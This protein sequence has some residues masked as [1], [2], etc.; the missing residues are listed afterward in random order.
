MCIHQLNLL[1]ASSNS[2]PLGAL[3]GKQHP[4]EARHFSSICDIMEKAMVNGD[5]CIIRCILVVFQVVFRF[6]NPQSE[7]NKESV[8]RSGLL[9]WQL[10]MAPVDQIG[11]EIQREV[12]LAISSGLNTLYQGEAELSKLLKL[13]LTEGER[14]SGLSQLR[15]VILTNLADQLQKNRFGSEEDDHYRLS[16]E[17]LHCILKTVVRESCLI[18]TK[19]QTVARDDFQKLLSTVPVVSP[20]LRYLM[21]VQNHL[22]SNTILIRPDDNDDSDSSL[23]GETMKVQELQSSILSLATKILVGCDEVLETLQ[24]VTTALINS[25]IPDRET[26]L[27]GLEQVTKATMLGHL[28]PVLLTSLMHPNL[29]TLILADALMPQLVQLVLYTSQTALL[30]KTQAPLF[31]EEPPPQECVCVLD[32]RILDE[33]EEPGFLTGLKIPAP[34]AAGKT[35]ETVHPVR[36]NYKFK[37]TVHI[38]GARCLYLRFDSRCSSQYDYDKVMTLT[39]VIYAGPNTNSRKVTEY[40]GNTLGYGSRSVLGTGWPKD[41]VKVEGDT[42]TFSFEMRSGREHNTPDKAMWGFSCTVR[43]QESSEDVSGG[44]PFL[45][46]LALGLSVLACSMLRILYNGPE[47]TREEE[48]C[49]DLLCSKLLQRCQWQVEANGAISPALTPSPSPLPLTIEEDREFIYPSDVLIPPPGLMPGTYFDLPR[50]RL[51]P[52]VMGRLR[53]VSGRAR[54]QFRPSIK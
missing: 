22:L 26:R 20:S 34:W 47:V 27:K 15:D 48:A 13:V 38:P 49:H 36:D 8:R 33:R 1:A 5:T 50:I 29:Q 7:Q 24:Q 6:F 3:L 21:A 54:P 19:C 10:L 30:L 53:E 16:D 43:A 51:P 46:D 25:D 12:C 39:L 32:I 17:L 4:I 9:L 35:V 31:T 44:L 28:L 45:A 37:E 14:N 11:T 40:G 52:G 23:Q 41:L 18:I 42:V 2:L